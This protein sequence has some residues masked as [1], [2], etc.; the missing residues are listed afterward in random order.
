MSRRLQAALFLLI[1]VQAGRLVAQEMV[2]PETYRV[3]II[4]LDSWRLAAT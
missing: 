1:A 2:A 4:A 3:R